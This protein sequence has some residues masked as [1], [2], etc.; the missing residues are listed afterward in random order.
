M[1]WSCSRHTRARSSPLPGRMLRP[2]T[3]SALDLLY[4]RSA[5][6]NEVKC[7]GRAGQGLRALSAHAQVRA[8]A[9]GR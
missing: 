4:P 6:V 5:G 3:G 7:T 2:E 9:S 1:S 8:T